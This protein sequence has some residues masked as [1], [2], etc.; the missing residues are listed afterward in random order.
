MSKQNKSSRAKK[1][2]IKLTPELTSEATPASDPGDDGAVPTASGMTLA[3]ELQEIKGSRGRVGL[4][5]LS[6]VE[7]L[8]SGWQGACLLWFCDGLAYCLV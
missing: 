5:L 4:I 3:E 2:L 1:T 6:A 7:L 8:D